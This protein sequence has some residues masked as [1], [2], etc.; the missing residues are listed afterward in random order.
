[1]AFD[2]RKLVIAALG[3]ALLQ[4][5]W[6]LIDGL[7]PASAAVTPDLYE[8]VGPG[9]LETGAIWTWETAAALHSRLW[10]PARLLTTPLLTLLDPRSS[11]GTMLDAVLSLM[12]LMIV[13]GI[14]GGAISRI[15]LVQVAELRQ[16]GAGEALRF[17]LSSWGPLILAPLCPLLGLAF[18]GAVAAA[19]GL[20]YR[21]PAVGP[22]LAGAVLVVPLAAGLVMTLLVAGLVAGWPLMHAAV[23]AGV[24]DAL[25]ALSRTF[26]YLSQRIGALAALLVFVWLEG[27]IG[28][29]L[30]DLLTGGVIRLTE[31]GLGLTAPGGAVGVLFGEVGGPAGAMAA[32]GHAF[33]L[34]A[35]RLLAHGWTYSFFWTA[36]ALLYLWLRHDVDGT[37]WSEIEPAAAETSR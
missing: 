24:E 9:G 2:L 1:M 17:A 28:L 30:V 32:A 12:W 23:A 16:A 14:C 8:A 5:G 3:L 26:G 19:F 33:W 10:E 15:A 37:P 27:L 13:W 20:L 35:V 18:C 11:W 36:A 4:L 7:F 21:L 31:W 34:A 29:E 22:A 25:D 6:S